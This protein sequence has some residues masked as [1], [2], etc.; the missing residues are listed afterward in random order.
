M[1]S[2]SKKMIMMLLLH[3]SILM[4]KDKSPIKG[5]S[6]IYFNKTKNKLKIDFKEN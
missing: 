3:I 1:D 2:I 6:K 4:L 5:Y